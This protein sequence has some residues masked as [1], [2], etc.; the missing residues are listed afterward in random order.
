MTLSCKVLEYSS[1]FRLHRGYASVAIATPKSTCSVVSSLVKKREYPVC[2]YMGGG[3]VHLLS[4]SGE[5]TCFHLHIK[6][7]CPVHP[8]GETGGLG[9]SNYWCINTFFKVMQK[10][11]RK[12]SLFFNNKPYKNERRNLL[13]FFKVMR[14]RKTK[15]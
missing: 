15:K 10:R 6:S 8:Q 4:R 12:S 9:L 1:V 5:P 13:P 14:R 2:G 3:G 7:D 11:L